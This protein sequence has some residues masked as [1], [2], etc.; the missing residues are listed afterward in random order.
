MHWISLGDFSPWHILCIASPMTLRC[1]RC[2]YETTGRSELRRHYVR[3]HAQKQDEVKFINFQAA[4]PT[5]RRKEEEQRK[6]K[7]RAKAT[8][9]AGRMEGGG[10]GKREE[11][12]GGEEGQEEERGR[13]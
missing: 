13:A 2:S 8:E 12:G 7:N 10:E 4:S 9:V 6:E 3:H 11:K 1:Q 5:F